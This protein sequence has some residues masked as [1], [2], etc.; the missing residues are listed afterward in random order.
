MQNGFVKLG[1][2]AC[3]LSQNVFGARI[4]WIN[5]NLFLKFFS[6]ALYGFGFGLRPGKEQSPQQIMQTRRIRLFRDHFFILALGLVPFTLHLESFGI[7]LVSRKRL[8]RSAAK[9]LRGAGGKVGVRVDND[10]E[11][12]GILGELM[13]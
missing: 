2:L 3:H 10:E 1:F 7:E 6:C 8:G 12:F 13:A 11:S 5:L 4:S 9:V